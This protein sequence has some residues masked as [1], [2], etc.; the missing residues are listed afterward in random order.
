MK[1]AIGIKVTRNF[2]SDVFLQDRKRQYDLLKLE[3]DFQKQAN[4]LRRKAEEVGSQY[5][6]QTPDRFPNV[7]KM[8][9]EVA[10]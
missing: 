6:L 3:R 7:C 8:W 9:L 5:L 1:L 10:I 4:V 2:P